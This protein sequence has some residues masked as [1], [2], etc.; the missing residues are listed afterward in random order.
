MLQPILIVPLGEVAAGVR[1]TGL[2]PGQGPSDDHLRH[3]EHEAQLERLDEVR[4]V[5]LALVVQLDFLITLLGLP[6][7]SEALF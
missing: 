4:V 6:H 5:D 1:P 7:R 3:V 2:L